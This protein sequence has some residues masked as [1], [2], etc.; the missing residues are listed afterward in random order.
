MSKTCWSEQSLPPLSSCRKWSAWSNR[1]RNP[2][3]CSSR[4]CA[5]LHSAPG[6]RLPQVRRGSDTRSG[7]SCRVDSTRSLL[8]RWSRKLSPRVAEVI[9]VG[10][11]PSVTVG[12]TVVVVGVTVVTVLVTGAGRRMWS[13]VDCVS[14]A[15][16]LAVEVES[17]T[18]VAEAGSLLLPPPQAD[19]TAAHK[20]LTVR[21]RRG[22]VDRY[23][24]TCRLSI[25]SEPFKNWQKPNQIEH[26]CKLLQQLLRTRACRKQRSPRKVG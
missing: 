3:R 10:R 5:P 20:R 17:V 25:G 7:S 15:A 8:T 23:R 22:G 21:E 24:V 9:A 12:A 13:A 18:A 14:T 19:N 11:L 6:R 26:N 4:R 16:I 1:F 2:C